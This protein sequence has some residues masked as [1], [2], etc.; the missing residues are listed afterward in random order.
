MNVLTLGARV[1]GPAL[2][3]EL[4]GTF[5]SAKFTGEERHVR[6][7]EKVKKLEAGKR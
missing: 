6:R 4:V 2:A 1:I 5:L 3:S 7:L